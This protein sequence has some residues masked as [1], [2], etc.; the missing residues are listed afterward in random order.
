MQSTIV[1]WGHTKLG[2]LEQHDLESLIVAAAREAVA[3]AAQEFR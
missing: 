1:G 3:R 2:R